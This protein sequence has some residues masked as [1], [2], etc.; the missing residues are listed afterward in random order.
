MRVQVI[1]IHTIFLYPNRP[2]T[3]PHTH[4]HRE[5]LQTRTRPEDASIFS[6]NSWELERKTDELRA[7]DGCQLTRR[8]AK[9]SA[10]KIS[11]PQGLL[12]A[13]RRRCGIKGQSLYC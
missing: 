4:T 10:R 9:R 12:C 8:P 3:P 13:D 7:S 5:C 1:S 2:C 11:A 6:S